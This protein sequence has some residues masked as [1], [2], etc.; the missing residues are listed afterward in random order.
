MALLSGP[1]QS[2]TSSGNAGYILL[3]SH[4][5]KTK[6]TRIKMKSISHHRTFLAKEMGTLIIRPWINTI[7]P[8]KGKPGPV[9]E[10]LNMEILVMGTLIMKALDTQALNMETLIMKA[11]GMKFHVIRALVTRTLITKSIIQLNRI[12]QRRIIGWHNEM[13]QRQRIH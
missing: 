1:F 12:Y 2:P 11:L 7:I 9:T 3:H 10:A 6:K 5:L 4:I 13:Y 8:D